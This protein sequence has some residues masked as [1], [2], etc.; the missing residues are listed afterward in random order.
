M[1]TN[2][3]I[4][5]KQCISIYIS[6]AQLAKVKGAKVIAFTG[7]PGS[8][9]EEISDLCLRANTNISSK[10]QEIHQLAYHIICELVENEFS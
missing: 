3:I 6:A 5:Q 1:I 8:K 2:K 9:L 10:A 4:I 7:K